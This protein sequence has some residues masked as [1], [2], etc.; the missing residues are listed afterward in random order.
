MTASPPGW[1]INNEILVD[2]T[3]KVD[4]GEPLT[5]E[6]QKWLILAANLLSNA[7]DEARDPDEPQPEGAP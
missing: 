7:L 3:R 5:P 6:D 1:P 4:R 2:L